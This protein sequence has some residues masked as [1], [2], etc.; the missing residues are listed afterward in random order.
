M[1]ELNFPQLFVDKCDNN[2]I[3][4]KAF[5]IKPIFIGKDYKRYLI[6]IDKVE[7]LKKIKPDFQL[8]Q[9]SDR[10]CFIVTAKANDN[11]I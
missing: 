2:E 5:D 3:I 4:E 9:K 8:L 7:I 11:I 1:I 6:E 10:G